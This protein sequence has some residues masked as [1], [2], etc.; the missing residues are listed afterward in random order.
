M[1]QWLKRI[2]LSIPGSYRSVV[3]KQ[4]GLYLGLKKEYSE[5]TENAILNMLLTSRIRTYSMPPHQYSPKQAESYY[6]PFLED[7]K[8]TLDDVI[9]R[10]VWYEFINSRQDWVTK[11]STPREVTTFAIEVEEYISDQIKQRL[12]H[13]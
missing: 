2:S 9:L 7:D 10:I 6:E 8:K 13:K 12:A 11:H 4:I 5:A 3:N 1:F